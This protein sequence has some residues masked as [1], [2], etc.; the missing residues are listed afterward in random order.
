MAEALSIKKRKA[1]ASPLSFDSL[2]SEAI[3]QIQQLSGQVWTDY[4]LHDPGITILEQLIYSITDLTYRTDFD[5]EDILAGED[6]NI[7]LEA[8]NLH[9]PAEVFPCRAATLLDY[10]KLLLDAVPMVDNVWLAEQDVPG[11]CRGLYRLA[12]KLAQQLDERE[13]MA[14]VDQIRA[15]NG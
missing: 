4:N 11:Q 9:A 15:V 3:K 14:A 2:R 8:Q 5:V 7:D 6:G 10:R 12:V 1:T 13:R